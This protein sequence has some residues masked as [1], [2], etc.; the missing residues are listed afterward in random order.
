MTSIFHRRIRRL[1]GRA[2]L[3][4][5]CASAFTFATRASA[6]QAAPAFSQIIVFGDSLSDTGNVYHR[7]NDV[8][9]GQVAYPSGSY[10][11]SNGRFTNS[12][13][14]DPASKLYVG[15]WHEQL[16]RTFLGLPAATNSLDGGLNY[17]F[18]GAT[19]QNGTQTRDVV[20]TPFGDV[21][22]TI[23]NMGKQMD[24]YLANHVVDPTALYIVWGGGNDLFDDDS[25][26]NVTA[27][28]TRASMLV[29]RLAN[30]GARY[31]LVPNV[32]PLGTIPKYGN[33]PAKQKSLDTA[34]INYRGELNADLTSTMS[35]LGAQGIKPTVYRLDSWANAVRIYASPGDYG[36]INVETAVQGRSSFNPDQFLYWDEIHPTTASHYQIAKGAYNAITQPQPVP[37][38]AVNLSTRV[39]VGTGENASIVGFIV[40][41][42]ISKQVLLRGLGP[43][44]TSRGVTGVL[45][46]PVLTLFD[47]GGNAIA[48][49]DNW[50]DTQAVEIAATG[51]P[52]QNDAESAI[53]KTLA[54]GHYTAALTGKN[55]GTGVGLVEV[56]DDDSSSSTL[57][58]LSTRGFVGTGEN[59]MIGGFIIKN[60]DSPIVVV[61]GI[62]PSL[63][64]SGIANP[65][66]D[67]QLEV[68]DANGAQI[69]ADDNWKTFQPQ[70]I[71]ATTLQPADDRE[72][73]LVLTLA[74][75]NYTAVVRGANNTTG[76]ALVEAYRIP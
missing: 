1:A 24:D 32:P 48:S 9:Q 74:P 4:L 38:K 69:A 66:L 43:S 13:D 21:T 22:I 73:A 52:P 70:A 53:L 39:S 49:N 54:P 30:A 12:S 64:S 47:D 7:V 18:G 34:A 17:A 23:D 51:I 63:S 16:A 31:I 27:T 61:R 36:F 25:A 42:D 2:A 5:A 29:S 44:L 15:V 55:G 68:H 57:A 8:T 65:L 45:A 59:V 41:G 35:T 58:N 3:V 19:T 28:A 56:Y 75:G 37:A 33:D 60:G 20:S 62:G 72:A 50:K 76:V 46:D 71:K 40:T 11:Y 6:Q 14:T 67:P 26:A 10:N